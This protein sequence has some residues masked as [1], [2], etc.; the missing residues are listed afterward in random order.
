MRK[1]TGVTRLYRRDG[2]RKVSFQYFHRDG[3]TETLASADTGDR[4]GIAGAL[5]IA[6]RK[7]DD[8]EQGVVVAGSVADLIDRFIDEV[9]PTHYIDRSKDGI[10]TRMARYTQLK[11][12]FGKMRPADLKMI[13]G[14]G[15]MDKRAKEGAPAG[16]N[17]EMAAM[18]TICNYAVRWG[19]IDVNPFV[20]MMQNVTEKKVREISR[21]QVARF[22]LWSI[23]QPLHLRTM[24]CA[25]MFLYLTGFRAAE[26]RP[27]MTSGL[28]DDGVRVISAK[29]KKGGQQV[30]KVRSWSDRLRTVVARAQAG[31]PENLAYLFASRTGKPYTKSGWG[32]VWHDAQFA[33]IA[34]FDDAARAAHGDP[35][36]ESAFGLVNH[37]AYFSLSDG[38]PAAITIKL[39]RRDGDAYDFAA[40]ANPATT[41]THYD[42]RRVKRAAATE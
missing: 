37:P 32:S 28:S 42:R 39:D 25:A 14:Y 16:V 33:W 2:L 29:R 30:V 23:R 18:Q 36:K 38:R 27:F 26:V 20:G 34:S 6:R 17:K 9:D 7:A 10:A 24:G 40:H 3:R 12:T 11:V 19:I 21:G 4:A 5:R 31:R 1:P 8:I 15:H 41:H 35:A 13:H 22:Y